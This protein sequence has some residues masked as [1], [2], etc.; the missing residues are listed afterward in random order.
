[1]FVQGKGDYVDIR[2]V[3]VNEEALTKGNISLCVLQSCSV[4]YRFT[5]MQ[6]CSGGQHPVVIILA[7]TAV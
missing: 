6:S 3:V 2:E 4:A 5:S 1:M 7:G